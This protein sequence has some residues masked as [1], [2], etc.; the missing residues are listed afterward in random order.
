MSVTLSKGL[1][2]V[3]HKITPRDVDFN[4][5]DQSPKY[6]FDEDS[7]KT[8]FFNAFF[9][10]FPPGEDFFVRS[11]IYYRGQIKDPK[12]QQEIT[13]FSIQEGHH[14][15]CHQDHLDV[16]TRQGYTS[17]ERE[18]KLIDGLGKWANN[19]FPLS[20]LLSTL[21]LEHFTAI[22]AHQALGDAELFSD[23]AHED[24]SPLFKWHAAEEIEHKAVAYDV[25]MKIDGRYWP[26]VIAMIGATVGL[27][28]LLPIRMTPLLFKDGKLFSWNTWRNGPLFLFGKNGMFV[29]PW[30]HYVQFFR[31]DFH[32]WDVQ[33]YDLTAEVQKVYEKGELLDIGKKLEVLEA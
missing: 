7:F 13:D 4:I 33:D 18:N 9:T 22:L 14:S 30:H 11:V 5:T 12:L 2:P 16:L 26:R 21:A 17:L 29:K 25:Y 31:K 10:T 23:P 6:W 28:L 32:P 27:L 19:H 24:F 15:R 3:M 8:H 1:P 20:S